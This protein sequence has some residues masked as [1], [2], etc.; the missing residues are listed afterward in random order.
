MPL[1]SS[2]LLPPFPPPSRSLDR[3]RFEQRASARTLEPY[4][5]LRG[6]P[7][8]IS[9]CKA[10]L[11]Q[12]HSDCC[13]AIISLIQ[14]RQALSCFQPRYQCDLLGPQ[15]RLA[16]P[17]RPI[18]LGTGTDILVHSAPPANPAS[19]ASRPI[20]DGLL[21][22]SPGST[23]PILD[24]CIVPLPLFSFCPHLCSHSYLLWSS[25]R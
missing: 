5:I 15:V 23:T 22:S 16:P 10:T 2:R 9:L 8:P 11:R 25:L 21:A 20:R 14:Y 19:N 4:P 24:P 17:P 13:I 7:L 6:T 1:V 18:Q 12:T 3:Y